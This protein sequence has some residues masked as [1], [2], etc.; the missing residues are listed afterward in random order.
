MGVPG[1]DSDNWYA[2]FASKGTPAAEADRVSQAVRRTLGNEA[3]KAKLLSSG[4]EPAPSTPA[5]L[6]ALLKSD[7][8]K[9]AHVVKAKNVKPD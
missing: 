1:V 7:S 8:I 2:L 6:S 4:A 9:W 5:E 3:V